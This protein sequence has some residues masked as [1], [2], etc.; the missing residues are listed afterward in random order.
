MR[1]L[2]SFI[3]RYDNYRGFDPETGRRYHGRVAATIRAY[4]DTYGTSS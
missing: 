4:R 2:A 3:V 1:K